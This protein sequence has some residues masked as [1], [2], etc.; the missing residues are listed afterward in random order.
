MQDENFFERYNLDEIKALAT[1]FLKNYHPLKSIPIPITDIIEKRLKIEI[2]PVENLFE[3]TSIETSLLINRK[4][5]I[6]DKDILFRRKPLARCILADEI[7]KLILFEDLYK[8]FSGKTIRTWRNHE[9]SFSKLQHMSIKYHS[10]CFGCLILIPENKLKTSIKSFIAQFEDD[11]IKSEKLKLIVREA[12]NDE[13]AH[14]FGVTKDIFA[15]RLQ[16][17][18]INIF[19]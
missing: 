18:K 17:D 19:K 8:S 14:V 12:A 7:G 2:T 6:V 10:Q 16:I 11:L 5:I 1:E 4:K 9:Q 15:F 3:R 13:L